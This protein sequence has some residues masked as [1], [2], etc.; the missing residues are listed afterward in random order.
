MTP[1]R[2]TSS[3]NPVLTAAALGV[4]L[5]TPSTSL[6]ADTSRLD[7]LVVTA[8][9]TEL[10]DTEVPY[11]AEIYSWQEIERSGATSLYDFLDRHTSVTVMPAFGNPFAQKLDMRGYGIGDGYQNIV[12]TFDGRRMNNVDMVPQFLGSVPLS[13][14]ER[15]EIVKGSGSVAQGDGATAG[16]VNIVTRQQ[17]G[18]NLSVAGGSHGLMASNVSAGLVRDYFSLNVLAENYRHDGFREEDANGD[19]DQA[20]ADNLQAQLKIFPIDEVELWF[21]K[22]RSWIET[23]YGK[24]LTLAEYRNDPAQSAG[25]T[26]NGQVLESHVTSVG[27]SVNMDYGLS[28][29]VDHFIEDKS[30]VYSS[31]WGSEYDYQSTDLAIKYQQ[32]GLDLVLGWQAF[33]GVREGSNNETSKDNAGLYLQAQYRWLDTFFAAGFRQEKVDYEY[34][35]QSGQTLNADHTLTAWDLGVNHRL[36]SALTVF[37]NLNQS[38]QAPDIDRFFSSG[39]FNSF[40]DPAKVRTFNAGFNYVSDINELKITAFYSDLENEIY[41]YN[42]GDWSTSINTNIDSSSKYGLEMEDQ[43][44]L[45]EQLSGNL[46]YA[47]V[48]AVIDEENKG[49]GAYNNKNLPGVSEHSI[50]MALDYAINDRSELSLI[51]IWRSETWAAND[52]ANSFDQKQQAYRMTNLGYRHRFD[53]MEL[54]VQIDNLFDQSNGLWIR[55]DTIYPVNFTRSWRV[56]LRADF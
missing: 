55:D 6:L 47:W 36:S 23:T 42:S 7:P 4:F 56:G 41:Y 24:S 16:I 37:S 40:I 52:F 30:S 5:V 28:L 21:G 27:G 32:S 48:R 17:D 53:Q 51:Q 46:N 45:T 35:P 26:Y 25:K 18:A 12:V 11:A 1:L 8:S 54:F 39:S 3:N 9:R 13:S 2:S 15:I 38:F 19:K 29:T 33:E 14:I 34:R 44:Q 22:S 49:G 10:L 31:G 50:S 20:D 43:L